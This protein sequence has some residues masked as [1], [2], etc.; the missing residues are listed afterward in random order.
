MYAMFESVLSGEVSPPVA[1][2]TRR[3]PAGWAEPAAPSAPG[4]TAAASAEPTV[5]SDEVTT[6][7]RGHATSNTY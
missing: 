1:N 6:R 3:R 4:S 2:C 7:Q 5:D